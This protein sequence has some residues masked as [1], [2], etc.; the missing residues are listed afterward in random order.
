[1]KSV[2]YVT[3]FG[4]EGTYPVVHER[5]RVEK[6]IQRVYKDTGSQRACDMM[7]RHFL[8]KVFHTIYFVV[9]QANTRKMVAFY[10]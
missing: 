1:M 5:D 9:I 6:P 2:D 10:H 8:E 7:N 4:R 3:F